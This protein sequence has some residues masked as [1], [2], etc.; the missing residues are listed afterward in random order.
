MPVPG[1]RSVCVPVRSFDLYDRDSSG[2]LI[3]RVPSPYKTYPQ[4]PHA[5]TKTTQHEQ[6]A[7]T[8][9]PATQPPSLSVQASSEWAD[10]RK[11]LHFPKGETHFSI[12]RGRQV[13]VPSRSEDEGGHTATTNA[14]H[15]A[16]PARPFKNSFRPF[17]P[18][19]PAQQS[20]FLEETSWHTAYS[21]AAGVAPATSLAR[22]S[23]GTTQYNSPFA[24]RRSLSKEANDTP[25]HQKSSP[26][27]HPVPQRSASDHR[28]PLHPRVPHRTS[29]EHRSPLRPPEAQRA[30][31]EN[32]SPLHTVAPAGAAAPAAQAAGQSAPTL[33]AGRSAMQMEG[34]AAT[35]KAGAEPRVEKAQLAAAQAQKALEEAIAEATM[36][37]E[38]PMAKAEQT[39]A[40]SVTEG[41]AAQ[42]VSAGEDTVPLE[43]ESTTPKEMPEEVLVEWGDEE[44]ISAKERD[45]D[46]FEAA[47]E[48]SEG[49]GRQAEGKVQPE[50]GVHAEVKVRAEAGVQA[51]VKLQAVVHVPSVGNLPAEEKDEDEAAAELAA[52]AEPMAAEAMP[53]AAEAPR[54]PPAT[55]PPLLSFLAPLDSAPPP[56]SLPPLEAARRPP[57]PPRVL[58]IH[59]AAEEDCSP[60]ASPPSA[61]Q[62]DPTS[63]AGP[64]PSPAAKQGR[65]SL[66]VWPA[67]GGVAK[68][69]A[70]SLPRREPRSSSDAPPRPP[71]DLA[72]CSPV[73]PPLL[74]APLIRQTS[75]ATV[76]SVPA[77]PLNPLTPSRRTSNLQWGSSSRLYVETADLSDCSSPRAS[78]QRSPLRTGG[79]GS[80]RSPQL[81]SEE[82]ASPTSNPSSLSPLRQ[83]SRTMTRR[84]RAAAEKPK[85]GGAR[86][87][88]K[89]WPREMSADELPLRYELT[90]AE[91]LT[92]GMTARP[93]LRALARLEEAVEQVKRSGLEGDTG[94]KL[95]A[96]AIGKLK[97]TMVEYRRC[98]VERGR[99]WDAWRHCEPLVRVVRLLYDTAAGETGG[100]RRAEFINLH[101]GLAREGYFHPSRVG[102][103]MAAF[104]YCW[105]RPAYLEEDDELT[106]ELPPELD[107]GESAATSPLLPWDEAIHA[108]RLLLLRGA[109]YGPTLHF[110]SFLE[111]CFE[112]ADAHLSLALLPADGADV[113]VPLQRYFDVAQLL[114]FHLTAAADNPPATP[115]RAASS[116]LGSHSLA[117][118][119]PQ[120]GAKRPASRRLRHA[121]P[122]PTE[123]NAT[124]LHNKLELLLRAVTEND[125]LLTAATLRAEFAA[126]GRRLGLRL[127]SS[128]APL[129][130]PSPSDST[131]PAVVGSLSYVQMDE[132]LGRMAG[133]WYRDL[134]FK[135]AA[136]ARERHSPEALLHA[137]RIDTEG[138]LSFFRFLDYDCDGSI[139]EDDFCRAVLGWAHTRKHGEL[140]RDG[141]AKAVPHSEL[142]ELTKRWY[143]AA[144]KQ[145]EKLAT[146]TPAQGRWKALR[147]I[148]M[149]FKA[150]ELRCERIEALDESVRVRRRPDGNVAWNAVDR[151]LELIFRPP[152]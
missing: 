62:S 27:Q 46:E 111:A 127:A 36:A 13:T 11:E 131:A 123:S 83:D 107:L 48:L 8:L 143:S 110:T 76:V 149:H 85:A 152:S 114:L 126:Y 28:S 89:G 18:A 91:N 140:Q 97:E 1:T 98:A 35:E 141:N 20:D 120:S 151:S 51:E 71:V 77:P 101:L 21:E 125:R 31:S 30:S 130:P 99:R 144:E 57:S 4:F 129:S 49:K 122:A 96:A 138:M 55:A 7:S 37:Q 117:P 5:R 40:K 59:A 26:L 115:S 108:W 136:V 22:S 25:T 80:L 95:L 106:R 6:T 50:A 88:P 67:E 121:W 3:P 146:L 145:A 94:Q 142:V 63:P 10:I 70:P 81:T 12:A 93:A 56:S 61:L 118:S 65:A 53:A 86:S 68:P 84:S 102:E 113:P 64:K 16:P 100:V 15:S 109:V 66:R 19:A 105:Q 41:E 90:E 139:S 34:G 78:P 2:I 82:E 87:P 132:A 148:G 33:A 23:R 112:L 74:L 14:C 69:A 54:A 43:E 116:P 72:A 92:L 73:S 52:E 119:T 60:H 17:S 124:D 32:R 137:S 150:V 103:E 104:P 147:D 135:S 24:R 29:S 47:T 128:S 45:L 79:S 9:P 134:T 75:K 42:V 39:Q 44:L 58:S 133:G 38:A